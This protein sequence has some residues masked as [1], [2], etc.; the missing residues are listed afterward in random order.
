MYAPS[1]HELFRAAEAGDI[2]LVREYAAIV[3]EEIA[4]AVGRESTLNRIRDDRGNTILNRC[5]WG[6]HTELARVL[7]HEY[8]LNIATRDRFGF[9]PLADATWYA[10]VPTIKFLLQAG[11]PLFTQTHDGMGL[12]D[13]CDRDFRTIDDRPDDVAATREMI[14]TWVDAR[15]KAWSPE[16]HLFYPLSVRK[17]IYTALV[18]ARSVDQETGAYTYENSTFL[19]WLPNEVLHIIFGFLVS[20]TVWEIEYK[21]RQ[22]ALDA[23]REERERAEARVAARLEAERGQV[24]SIIRQVFS[25]SPMREALADAPTPLTMDDAVAGEYGAYVQWVRYAR[26]SSVV[27]GRTRNFPSVDAL[28]P[29]ELTLLD[30]DGQRSLYAVAENAGFA[31]HACFLAISPNHRTPHVCVV[32]SDLVAYSDQQTQQQDQQEAGSSSGWGIG[33]E[34]DDGSG[35]DNGVRQHV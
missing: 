9:T 13:I 30:V 3:L 4:E 25:E 35:D 8:G 29:Y 6:G 7:V 23:Q 5:L 14:T 34:D 17:E 15:R 2:G 10:R 27:M 21:K 32:L 19:P 20:H 33:F 1:Q 31:K 11:S 12:L 22:A 18:I 28:S 24:E 16:R 26:D